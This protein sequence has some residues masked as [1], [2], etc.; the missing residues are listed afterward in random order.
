MRKTKL[1]VSMSIYAAV[2]GGASLPGPVA[3]AAD[4]A[5]AERAA[6]ADKAAPDGKATPADR[7]RIQG[8][9]KVVKRVKNGEA[10]TA[11]EVADQSAVLAFAGD[12]VTQT[13]D[14][15]AEEGTFKLDPTQS[16]RRITLAGKDPARTFEGIYELAGDTLTLA[17]GT[18]EAAKTPPK[19]F[20]G[21]PGS[22]LLV[23]E[24]QPT[25]APAADAGVV[26][27]F[28]GKDLTGWGYKTGETFDGKA[29]A[30]D[31]RYSAKD[32][33]IVVN[34]GTGIAQLWTTK[35]FPGDFELR[36]EFR[37]AVN[38][39]S[40][41][42]VR[43]PQL[44]VRDYLVAGPY[45]ELKKYKPQD[46]NEIVVVVKGGVAHCTCNGEVLNAALKVP[47]TGGIGLE[48]DRGQMEYRNLRLRPTK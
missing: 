3:R 11:K 45:K 14:G 12:A 26:E 22:G 1:L 32:G 44:Q 21:G 20:A 29:E 19:D 23:L 36:L 8:T 7:D 34:S 28:N 25:A 30:S 33:M 47:E 2:A 39:D 10:A 31:K 17:Y 42:F 9:W 13:K 43:K 6:P 48:A 24:R 15:K 27:L 18:G 5:T 4:A 37:A 40:G 16:P 38:A 35:E 46:W 41:L